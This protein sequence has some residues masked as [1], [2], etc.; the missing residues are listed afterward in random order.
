LKATTFMIY[1]KSLNDY[2]TTN[3]TFIGDV[4]NQLVLPNWLGKLS[5][6]HAYANNGTG[7]LYMLSSPN[8][9]NILNSKTAGTSMVGLS[10]ASYINT[11]AGQQTKPAYIPTNYIVYI[12]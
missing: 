10:N 9:L 4:T 11:S 8:L 6:I 12:E 3:K 1:A 2:L 5:N 7:Y